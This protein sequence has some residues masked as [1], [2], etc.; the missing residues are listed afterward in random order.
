MSHKTNA[1]LSAVAVIDRSG[2]EQHQTRPVAAAHRK[3]LNLLRLDDASDF[4]IGSIDR[5]DGGLNLDYCG[6]GLNLQLRIYRSGFAVLQVNVLNRLS[7][8][9]GFRY[10]DVIGADGK[11]GNRVA[12]FVVRGY[13]AVQPDGRSL[14]LDTGHGDH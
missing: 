12:S 10:G 4:G 6:G 1:A 7:S 14:Q 3:L 13:C 5:F 9:S 2:R 8:E 11:S